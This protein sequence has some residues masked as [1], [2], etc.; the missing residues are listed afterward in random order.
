MEQKEVQ[1][2]WTNNGATWYVFT[3]LEDEV[4]A[5]II[6]LLTYEWS[7]FGQ[8]GDKLEIVDAE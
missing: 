3:V 5:K 6:E 4:T 2:K 7:S 8:D 1:I